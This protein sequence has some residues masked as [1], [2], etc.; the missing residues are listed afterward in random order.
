VALL[1][2]RRGQEMAELIRR[3]GGEPL[4]VPALREE[5]C[6]D[7]AALRQLLHDLPSR[8]LAT[9][10]FQTGVGVEYL[11]R[12]ISDLD[13]GAEPQLRNILASTVIIARGPKPTTALRS[14][15]IRV[16][17]SVPSPYTTDQLIASLEDIE[18]RDRTVL[19]AQHGGENPG[20]R[21]LL[22]TR[23][24]HVEELRL[25]RWVLPERTDPLEGLLT[26]IQA[27]GVQAVVFTSASQVEHLCLVAEASNQRPA[28]IDALCHG[29]VVAAVG[30]ICAQALRERGI[31]PEGGI[32]EPNPPK[33]VPLVR[34]L[35]QHMV[36]RRSRSAG[37]PACESPSP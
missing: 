12:A 3:Y 8:D 9:A 22:E 25:Y 10:V 33:M 19:V 18:L 32:I 13:D 23:G 4:F 5:P 26:A 28:L 20:L 14:L 34:A 11:F 30:P 16:D 37:V 31:Q 7:L 36:A 29:P 35:A 6:V 15:N 17:R 27:G 1:E 24:A 21:S 2:A